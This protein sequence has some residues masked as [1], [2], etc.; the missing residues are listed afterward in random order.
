MM[1]QCP[2]HGNQFGMRTSEDI[3]R[4]INSGE[5][6]PPFREIMYQYDGDP[7]FRMLVSERFSKE[8]DISAEDTPDLP[9]QYPNWHSDLVGMCEVCVD[10]AI[11]GATRAMSPDS[12]V[13]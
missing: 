13:V 8:N 12:P 7:C 3:A 2:R 6:L 4:A 10:E 9:E 11:A 5:S 1:I